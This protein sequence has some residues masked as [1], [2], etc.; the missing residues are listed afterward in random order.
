[1]IDFGSSNVNDVHIGF[2]HLS[3]L[4]S[5]SSLSILGRGRLK[6]FADHFYCAICGQCGDAE[7]LKGWWFSVIKNAVGDWRFF[8]R[9][10]DDVNMGNIN[11][12]LSTVDENT[13]MTWAFVWNGPN[14]TAY[15][16]KDGSQIASPT[17]QNYSI[18]STT[19][20]FAI[21]N[22]YDGNTGDAGGSWDM[23]HILLYP[24]VSLAANEIAAHHAGILPRLENAKFWWT[25]QYAP[26]RNELKHASGGE[27]AGTNR[28]GTPVQT[29]E[30]GF[31]WHW[32]LVGM[33]KVA[34]S[35]EASDPGGTEEGLMAAPM[36][37]ELTGLGRVYF[38]YELDLPDNTTL[39]AS[40]KSLPTEEGQYENILEG[41][42]DI[43]IGG[44][45]EPSYSLKKLT[46]NV[47]LL[48]KDRILSKRFTGEFE[49]L[50]EGSACRI[51]LI[52]PFV[53]SKYWFT[54][55]KGVFEKWEGEDLLPKMT[56]FLGVTDKPLEG[57]ASLGVISDDIF[58]D[59]ASYDDEGSEIPAIYGI[60]DEALGAKT[61]LRISETEF[62]TSAG[63]LSELTE[64]FVDDILDATWSQQNIER[65]GRN[66]TE[67][68]FA[69]APAAD[70][71]VKFNCKGIE[72]Y[73]DGSGATITNSAE[74]LLHMIVNWYY[75]KYERGSW[76]SASEIDAP[77]NDDHFAKVAEF[78][79]QFSWT[80]KKTITKS[81]TG[82]Q[83]CNGWSSSW[84][85]PI[86]WGF[87]GKLAVRANKFYVQRGAQ[88][89]INESDALS[90]LKTL[91]VTSK[92]RDEVVFVDAFSNETKVKDVLRG[93]NVVENISNS[94]II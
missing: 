66:F 13:W 47:K 14:V 71:V 48:D 21:N 56:H 60:Y 73:G 75:G 32:P 68:L 41:M 4:D 16:Y 3:Y 72:K 64:V 1:M 76:Y 51:R 30:A 36:Y 58:P 74:Q 59:C 89:L 61:A 11:S 29:E 80:S 26:G 93:H 57:G 82:Y 5:L 50:I 65:A 34:F 62:L 92:L 31:P 37:E 33:Y 46:A 85:I 38:C 39:R 7:T 23:D 88:P 15:F 18:S 84:R 10:G 67:I 94:W 91:N 70:V 25:G 79:R 27:E 69:P 45:V 9:W 53:L 12:G 6:T 55:F 44:S 20:G 78:M 86:F 52:S 28:N 22:R 83:L 81:T 63:F 90:I 19:N 17:S 8:F 87:D 40:I 77:I 42:S 24:G 2:G 35:G 49:N 43:N 54:C